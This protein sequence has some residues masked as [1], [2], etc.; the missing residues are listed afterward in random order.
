MSRSTR[1]SFRQA[2]SR[3]RISPLISRSQARRVSAPGLIVRFWEHE[4]Q[5]TGSRSLLRHIIK[6]QDIRPILLLLV[7][8]DGG[9][10]P[11][12]VQGYHRFADSRV[13]YIFQTIIVVSMEPVARPV[14]PQAMAV[15]SPVC[16]L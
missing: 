5:K 10:P 8:H 12:I 11:K 9:Y 13:D 6:K 3:C 15:T 7:P 16:P 4:I 14:G 2:L 1:H